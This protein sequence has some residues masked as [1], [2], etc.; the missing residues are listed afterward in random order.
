MFKNMKTTLK[1]VLTAIYFISLSFILIYL[2][3]SNRPVIFC[4]ALT[5]GM[6]AYLFI[7]YFF[8]WFV[9]S[10]KNLFNQPLFLISIFIPFYLFLSIGFWSWKGHSINFTADGFNNFLTISKLPLFFLAAAVPLTSIVNNIHRTI[11]TEKK[12]SEAER[13]NL[14]DAYYTH[15]KHTLELLRSITSEKVT[16]FNV[17]QHLEFSFRN[18]I[19]LYHKTYPENSPSKTLNHIPNPELLH[20]L[21][22]NWKRIKKGLLTVNNIASGLE[23]KRKHDFYTPL[24]L[25]NLYIIENAAENIIRTLNFSNLYFRKR[26]AF[27][28]EKWKY[29]GLT[30]SDNTLNLMLEQ[31]NVVC[32]RFVDI[33]AP[34]DENLKSII[35]LDSKFELVFS[36]IG[37]TPAGHYLDAST[38]LLRLEDG[39]KLATYELKRHE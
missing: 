20:D 23:K 18:P 10:H 38:V 29:R 28:Y 15:F 31:L 11:Q 25:I 8:G 35:N 37:Y 34:F 7:I 1:L 30:G 21:T 19:S 26:P 24:A 32:N 13:K 12:I 36:D 39:D 5:I 9:L 27:N 17:N 3:S 2:I 16:I 22:K 33:V 6:L 14:S 4:S